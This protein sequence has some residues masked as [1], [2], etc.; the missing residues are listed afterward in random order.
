MN[1]TKE[2]PDKEGVFLAWHKKYAY[3][4]VICTRYES[5]E[6]ANMYGIRDKKDRTKFLVAYIVNPEDA[7]DTTVISYDKFSSFCF[8]DKP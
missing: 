1:W 2:Y 3:P 8:I 5:H 4:F 6:Y 7:E